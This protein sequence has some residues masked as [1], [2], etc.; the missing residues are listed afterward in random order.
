MRKP[1]RL[2][3]FVP[4]VLIASLFAF[5]SDRGPLRARDALAAVESLKDKNYDLSS[6]DVFRKTIVQIKDN[7]VDPSRINPK[8]MFT[9]ALEAVERQVPEVM[10][11]VGGPPCDDKPANKEPGTTALVGP[12]NGA[13]QGGILE[14]NRAQAGGCAH[15][16]SNIPE[17]HVRVTVGNQTKEFDYRDIDS[18]WQ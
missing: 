10:V 4:A 14:T 11:D 2:V 13:P 1:A 15:A 3:V 16:N 6:L 5:G 8:E 9:A 7:Y 18:I 12:S 17:G